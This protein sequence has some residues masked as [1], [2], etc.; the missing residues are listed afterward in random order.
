MREPQ[1][2]WALMGGSCEPNVQAEVAGAVVQEQEAC[3]VGG[4]TGGVCQAAADAVL[5]AV[6]AVTA[7]AVPVVG[8][9]AGQL[10]MLHPKKPHN[11]THIH[12]CMHAY[13]HACS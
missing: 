13:I 3:A 11:L 9:Y 8:G 1:P 10:P 7:E 6:A 2:R 4:W 5:G 12:V